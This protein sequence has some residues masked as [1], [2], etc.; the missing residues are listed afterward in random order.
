M[1]PVPFAAI[2]LKRLSARRKLLGVGSAPLLVE[3]A[4][5][6]LLAGMPRRM[7]MAHKG[8]WGKEAWLLRPLLLCTQQWNTWEC[9]PLGLL[10]AWQD[11][12]MLLATHQIM[13]FRYLTTALS[14]TQCTTLKLADLLH[15]VI[16]TF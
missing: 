2:V 9:P 3:S 16:L 5:A 4:A 11:I 12:V 14:L 7:V 13:T 15:E 1:I 10:H 8:F 6:N